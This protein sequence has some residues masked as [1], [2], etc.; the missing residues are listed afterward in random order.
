MGEGKGS[1]TF[2]IIN[3]MNS[4]PTESLTSYFEERD[5]GFYRY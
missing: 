3:N 2:L 4:V 1:E 5:I